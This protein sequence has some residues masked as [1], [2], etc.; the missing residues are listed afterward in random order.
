MPGCGIVNDR[1]HQHGARSRTEKRLPHDVTGTHIRREAKRPWR[2]ANGDV[3]GLNRSLAK[4]GSRMCG[5]VLLAYMRAIHVGID[6]RR[7][8]VRVAEHLLERPKI[9][10]SLQHVCREGVP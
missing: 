6:L 8:D 7:A 9:G 5:Q 2:A 1:E 10:A 3:G 4:T